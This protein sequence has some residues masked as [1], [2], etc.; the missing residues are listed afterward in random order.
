MTQLI[1]ISVAI[2]FIDQMTINKKNRQLKELPVF[3]I[4]S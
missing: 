4:V 1:P 3:L 2:Y